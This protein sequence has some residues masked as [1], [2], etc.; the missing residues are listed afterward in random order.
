MNGD[1]FLRTLVFLSLWTS[2]VSADYLSDYS[3]DIGKSPFKIVSV[4]WQAGSWFL[5]LKE[6]VLILVI[7]VLFSVDSGRWFYWVTI[8]CV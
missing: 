7:D 1:G 8:A 4:T 3:S 5:R 2:L 6:S